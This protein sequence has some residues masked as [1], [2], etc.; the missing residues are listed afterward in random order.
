[1]SRFKGN[2]GDDSDGRRNKND[3]P[4]QLTEVQRLRTTLGDA[5]GARLPGAALHVRSDQAF[6]SHRNLRL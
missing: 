4:D 2:R 1:M 3:R 6:A 5:K